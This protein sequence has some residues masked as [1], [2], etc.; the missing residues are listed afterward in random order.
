MNAIIS[1]IEDGS[2]AYETW[3]E[4]GDIVL[5]VNNNPVN[6]VIDFM[7]FAREKILNMKI[8]R[9]NKI[10]ALKIRQKENNHL[11]VEFKPFRTKACRNK[12]LFC[13]VNQLPRGMR[14]SLYLKDDDYRMSFLFGNY[15]TLTNLSKKDMKR[16]IDQKLSPLYI[17]VHTT[18]NKLRRKM[19][20]NPKAPD[21]LKEIQ[22]LTD[23]KIRIHAQIV[24]CPGLNDRDELNATI[25][26]LQKFYP[27]ISSIAV[28]PV[29]LT[30][31]HK[32]SIKQ[33]KKEDALKIIES[34]KY[35][36]RRLKKRHGDPIVYPADELYLKAELPL[37]ALNE[38][39]D[40]PQIENGV[41]LIPLFLQ[42]AKN[43]KLP[44][45]IKPKKIAVCTGVSFAPYLKDF[46]RK[47][48]TINELSM[49]VFEVENKF[50]GSTITVTGLLTGKDIVKTIVGKT[51]ADCL[52]VPDITLRNE[53]D[54]F[55]DNVSLKD[56]EE[57]LGM[58]VK[59]IEPTP[60]GLLTEIVN[61]NK[62]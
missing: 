18:N 23:N 59:P 61:G 9:G 26:D 53:S 27:Y 11:G 15:I 25:K 31:C 55:L 54:V 12:C 19:L 44:K 3:L 21:I 32:S 51:E 6:D 42:S 1:H 24:V 28:V 22:R 58:R 5:S 52:L 49:E 30:K 38:Y 57:S 8:Q 17:S 40:L 47:L 43:L 33:I 37:P 2:V 46:A 41:G 7:Y 4:K 13:F 56:M 20:G 45:K 10:H 34:V 16:V 36:R 35:F 62:R 29:G 14:K 39:G 48:N 60:E 50:F